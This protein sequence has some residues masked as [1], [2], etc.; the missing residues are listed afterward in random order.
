MGISLKINFYY[1]QERNFTDMH[2]S[3]IPTLIEII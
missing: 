2:N 1:G 3:N